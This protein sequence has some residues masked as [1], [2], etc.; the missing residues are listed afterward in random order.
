MALTAQGT[1]VRRAADDGVSPGGLLRNALRVALTGLAALA[2]LLPTLA[3]AADF[4]VG[5]ETPV[6]ISVTPSGNQPCNIEIQLPDG[7]R[8]ER[9][10][11]PPHFETM[12]GYTPRTDGA[13]TITWEGRFR[14]YGSLSVSGCSGHYFQDIK[15]QP[16]AALVRARWDNYLAGMP[17]RQ[18]EC[19]EYGTGRVLVAGAPAPRQRAGSPD[20][21]FVKTV[22]SSCERFVSMP[23]RI[24]VPCPVSR[25]DARETRCEDSYVVG[26]GR[27]ARVLDPDAALGRRGSS[28]LAPSA[29]RRA[30][31][32]GP[33]RVGARCRSGPKEPAPVRGRLRQSCHCA[34]WH[35]SSAA[36]PV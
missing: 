4:V 6:R 17:V 7:S 23:R 21:A 33:L 8:I 25:G 10:L 1:A 3:P 9:E 22:V 32:P 35:P 29:G 28:G 26:S 19:V 2:L 15:V 34:Q 11:A 36:I 14:F 31:H 27:K 18:R 20:E 13:Q 24:D 5:R 30:A 12:V 16:D